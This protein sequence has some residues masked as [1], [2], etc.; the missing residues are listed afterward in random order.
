MGTDLDGEGKTGWAVAGRYFWSPRTS[1]SRRQ[2][3]H[4]VGSPSA[5]PML[6][7][8]GRH[9]PTVFLLPLQVWT[10]HSWQHTAVL[11]H[12]CSTSPARLKD[13][14]LTVKGSTAAEGLRNKVLPCTAYLPCSLSVGPEDQ[15]L[16]PRRVP[17]RGRDK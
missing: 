3:S 16:L 6:Y 13:P 2:D 11:F 4:Y 17:L 12:T 8:P 15:D 14:H 1:P 9:T 5:A 10:E 7:S